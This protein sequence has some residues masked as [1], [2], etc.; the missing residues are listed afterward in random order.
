MS[1]VRFLP[2]DGRESDARMDDLLAPF[3]S[4]LVFRERDLIGLKIHPGEKDNR[5]HLTPS[6]L[7]DVLKALELPEGRTFLMDTTV[8]Y[9][10][11]R[12]TAPEYVRLSRE[13]GF[14]PPE[15]P[16]LLVMDGLR[17]TDETEV[18]LP[19]SCSTR[20]ARMARGF[21]DVDWMIV[22][23]HF[24]GHALAGF[25][26]AIKNLGM[27][28]ASRGGKLFMHSN[29]LPTVRED[30]CIA[31]GACATHCPVGAIEVDDH[32]ILDAE[33]CIGCGECL[34]RCPTGA[35]SV[36]WN[37]ASGTFN[38]R[39]AEYALA[40]TVLCRTVLYVNLVARVTPNCDCMAGE[41]RPLVADQG[42]LVSAD[43]VAVDQASLDL[44]TAAPALPDS[45]LG[46][47]AGPGVDKFRIRWPDTDGTVQ[48]SVAE[49][50][51][52]G[53]RSYDLA[54]V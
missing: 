22:V 25:G 31:C 46:E 27:G 16:P 18:S 28:C 33:T 7:S 49:R 39:L 47:E 40:A 30:K 13:H 45:G 20:V 44:V 35:L 41:E 5:S 3:K 21:G 36:S 2:M 43:P 37:Q 32:A 52:L 9:R 50:I 12:M 24:K 17:G 6:E 38:R 54:K 48:L 26:G 8:L 42:I 29:V 19:E 23:S 10:G 4:E 53:S 1:E 15:T 51:G 11:S 34:Q 14:V